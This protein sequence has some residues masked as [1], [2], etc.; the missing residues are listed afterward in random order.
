[1]TR[2]TPTLLERTFVHV[3][4]VG[5]KTERL[6]RQSNVRSWGELLRRREVRGISPRK[7]SAIRR[8]VK[9]SV[10]ALSDGRIEFFT[11]TLP[12][13]DLWRVYDAFADAVG[14]VDIETTGLSK[15]Y[16]DLTMV[17]I[18]DGSSPQLY[19]QNQNMERLVSDIQK[20]KCIVTFNGT[21]FDLPFLR[22]R[23]RNIQLPPAHIDLRYLLKRLGLT[24]GLHSIEKALGL[25]RSQEIAD[26]TGFHATV[27]WNQYTRGNLQSLELLAN[28]NI[29]DTT[30]LKTLAEYAIKLMKQGQFGRINKTRPQG[31]RRPEFSAQI[32][33]DSAAN[34][35]LSVSNGS[36]IGISPVK[37]KFEP[38]RVGELVRELTSRFGRPPVAVGIDLSGSAKRKSGWACLRDIASVTAR[39]DSDERIFSDTFSARPD[40]VSIDS[41]LGLPKGRDCTRDDCE[42]RRHGIMRECE[43]ELKKR[44]INVF[45]CLLPSMQALTSRGVE[46]RRALERESL[47]VIESYPGAAQ[48]IL[49]LTRKKVDTE[50]LRAGLSSLGLSGEFTKQKTSH[51]ELDA[52]TA[53][54]VGYFYLAGRYESLGNSQEGYLIIPK[55]GVSLGTEQDAS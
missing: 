20:Y 52:I 26:V 37:N 9:E 2:N 49:R 31:L 21:L 23:V 51:D 6:L 25:S 27:L 13:R 54:L 1:L 15:F 12:K 47:T 28:Y 43:R 8:Y 4:G 3:P 38:I 22:L 46:L 39:Y 10:S 33:R 24:G 36:L 45:P 42:C 30:V 50:E 35:A 29:A 5:Y 18:F 34:H 55:V 11:S 53:A 14:F 44:G 32:I 16:D 40:V 48:D 17:C 7:L 41:P 19:V